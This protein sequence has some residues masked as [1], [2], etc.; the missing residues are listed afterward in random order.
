MTIDTR[1]FIGGLSIYLDIL[2]HHV[3]VRSCF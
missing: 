1:S 3:N 2:Q